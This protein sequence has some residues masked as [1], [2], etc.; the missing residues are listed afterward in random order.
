MNEWRPWLMDLIAISGCIGTTL[1]VW[2]VLRFS[3][4]YVKIHAAAKG[5]VLGVL[6]IA[7]VP[8]LG[9]YPMLSVRALLVA[10]LLLLTA[11]VS[12]HVLARL[13]WV[14]SDAKGQT[15]EQKPGA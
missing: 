7:I 3:N 14:L 9:G 13:Q 10:L 11:P 12:A 15:R 1:S 2:G 8:I 4:V 5:I 6:V